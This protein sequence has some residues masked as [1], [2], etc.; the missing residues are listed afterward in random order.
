MSQKGKGVKVRSDFG[1]NTYRSGDIDASGIDY[2]A[3]LVR[4]SFQ[5]ADNSS[6]YPVSKVSSAD[7]SLICKRLGHF[8]K[9]TITQFQIG[10][11]NGLKPDTKESRGYKLLKEDF[12]DHNTFGHFRLKNGSL[13]RIFVGER[14]GLFYL[15]FFD[16]KGGV[17]AEVH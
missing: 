9:R 10:G 14:G 13:A 1:G 5:Q 15:L 11:K 4:F 2:G 17:Y 7:W 8:E 3:Q 12:S 16:M 6:K